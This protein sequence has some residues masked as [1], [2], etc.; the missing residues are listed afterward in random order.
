MPRLIGCSKVFTKMNM[1]FAR[2]MIDLLRLT[3]EAKVLE[4]GAGTGR[5]SFRIARKLGPSGTLFCAG[6]FGANG[7]Q[8]KK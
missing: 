1:R 5:D 2:Q 8:D 7:A 3:P 4:I 6:S